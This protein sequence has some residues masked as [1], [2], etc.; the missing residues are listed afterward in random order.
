MGL[1][2]EQDLYNEI[3]TL[4]EIGVIPCLSAFRALPKTCFE[5]N[6]NP[7][8]SYLLKVYNHSV[9]LLRSMTGDIKEL[10]PVCIACRN[11]MLII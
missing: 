5:N 8:N 9:K 7:D 10:G 6:L 4:A 1:D 2:Q 11:N 3:V